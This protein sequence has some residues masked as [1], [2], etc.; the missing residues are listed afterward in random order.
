MRGMDTNHVYVAKNRP[1]KELEVGS[2]FQS[3]KEVHESG[4]WS[5]L[6]IESLILS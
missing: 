2:I 1:N 5:A 6:P 4:T 3:G